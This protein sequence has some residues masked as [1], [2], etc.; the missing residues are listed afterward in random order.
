MLAALAVAPL[1]VWC[2]IVALS[3]YRAVSAIIHEFLNPILSQYTYTDNAAESGGV[4]LLWGGI[5]ITLVAAIIVACLL[6]RFSS[7]S[8]FGVFLS[9]TMFISAGIGYGWLMWDEPLLPPIDSAQLLPKSGLR[10]TPRELVLEATN[11][12][13]F[14]HA[15][16]WP[17]PSIVWEKDDPSPKWLHEHAAEIRA[18]WEQLAPVLDWV[19]RVNNYEGF[20]DYTDAFTSPIIAFKPLRE[21]A[22]ASRQMALLLASEGR[23]DEAV[24][25]LTDLMVLGRRLGDGGR[26][27]VT[28]MIGCVLEKNAIKTLDVIAQ[29]SVF[30]TDARHTMAALLRQPTNEWDNFGRTLFNEVT[31][32]QSMLLSE[33]FPF[34]NAHFRGGLIFM[35]PVLRLGFN[36]NATINRYHK[37]MTGCAQLAKSASLVALQEWDQIHARRIEKEQWHVKNVVGRSLVDQAV[38]PSFIKI[39]TAL[40]NL[41]E[42]RAS[43]AATLEK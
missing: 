42:L 13:Q 9:I 35:R 23:A 25:I 14:G 24:P 3:Q 6:L 27:L 22:Y 36:R 16:N 5:G 31:F 1:G 34:S 21:F 18:H 26:A 2:G 28:L 29:H 30:S 38:S 39:A 20:D 40:Q 19:R 11:D 33:D 7:K 37:E 41:R 17:T 10:R 12:P 8:R 43:L 32:V 15:K 4:A